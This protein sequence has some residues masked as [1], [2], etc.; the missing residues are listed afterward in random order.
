[1]YSKYL[2]DFLTG[3]FAFVEDENRLIKEYLKEKFRK[4]KRQS[5]GGWEESSRRESISNSN[6]RNFLSLWSKREKMRGKYKIRRESAG[7][8]G[9]VNPSEP[10]GNNII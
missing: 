10:P 7:E 9:Q 8:K 2:A 6:G 4:D 5:P 1:L 3:E